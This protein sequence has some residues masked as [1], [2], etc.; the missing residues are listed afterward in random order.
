[1]RRNWLAILGLLMVVVLT[2]AACGG[3]DGGSSSGSASGNSEDQSDE[4][5]DEGI[6]EEDWVDEASSL[7]EDWAG[8]V[9]DVEGTD[10]DSVAELGESTT[11][12]LE[13]LEGLGE[14]EDIADEAD[15]FISAVSDINDYT[16]EVAELLEEGEDFPD[17]LIEQGSEASADIVEAGE[18]LELDCDLSVIDE[19]ADTSD[20]F[21]DDL[22]DDF[23]DDF[24]DDLGDDP[25]D[26]ISNDG[27][28]P[29]IFISEYGSDATFDALADDCYEGDFVACDELYQTSPQEPDLD[30]YE[31]Y[32][33]TC[34]GRL[35]VETTPNQ[36]EIL[37]AES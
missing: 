35:S 21:S 15:D 20:D 1:M 18:E 7:C 29:T 25:A 16:T 10:P 2:A 14:P 32:G 27:L 12:F 4:P 17:E 26:E 3:D 11:T 5:S 6:S 37:A 9:E 13:D 33:A 28:D 19:R 30:T 24:S 31:G 34:G 22:S 36:C 23:S 8:E